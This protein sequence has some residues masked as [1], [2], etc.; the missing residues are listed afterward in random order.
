MAKRKSPQCEILTHTT[1]LCYAIRDV[2]NRI[3]AVHLKTALLPD[4]E[5]LA[6]EMCRTETRHLE[7]LK[8]LYRIE[9]GVDY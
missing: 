5:T 1:I 9:T 7:I 2:E 6:A 8:N 3:A 4:G